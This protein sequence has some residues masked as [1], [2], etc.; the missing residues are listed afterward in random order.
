MPEAI[1]ISLCIDVEPDERCVDPRAQMPWSGFEDL[2][3]HMMRHRELL[4]QATGSK[5]RFCWNIRLDPQIEQTYGSPGW[6]VTHY[7]HIFESLAAEG[8]EIGVH[9]HAWRWD[10]ADGCWIADHGNPAWVEH[11]VRSSIAV[12]QDCFG[13]RPRVFS[14]GDRFMSNRVLKLLDQLGIICDLTIEPGQRSARSQIA[15]EKSTGRLPDFRKAPKRP[16]HPSP[17]NYQRPGR[18]LKR[19]IWAVPVSTGRPHGIINGLSHPLPECMAIT[20]GFPFPAMRQILEQVLASDPRP[21]VL[22]AG[23]TDVTLDGFNRVQFE[24][25]LRHLAAHPLREQFAF[26]PPP[27]AVRMIAGPVEVPHLR[28]SPQAISASKDQPAILQ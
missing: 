9:T 12:Y 27:E 2:Y 17:W 15:G 11:C 13:R 25:F 6:V 10:A 8:D 24:L 16:F 14:L 3:Q 18:W 19:K 21:Y 20:I 4:A 23:R 1:P 28:R 7:R 26:V 5:V 22:T